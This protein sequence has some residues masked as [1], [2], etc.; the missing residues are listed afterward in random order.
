MNHTLVSTGDRKDT[1]L[2]TAPLPALTGFFTQYCPLS[3]LTWPANPRLRL[4]CPGGKS[5]PVCRL[6][7]R[8]RLFSPPELSGILLTRVRDHQPPPEE[9]E[10]PVGH[11]AGASGQGTKV[12]LGGEAGDEVL[13]LRGG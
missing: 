6:E 12:V 10:G 3:L 5:G 4:S 13:S 11:V 9:V 8:G 1:A 2:A 7:G